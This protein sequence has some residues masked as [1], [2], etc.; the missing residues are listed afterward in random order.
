MTQNGQQFEQAPSGST[1]AARPPVTVVEGRRAAIASRERKR[2]DGIASDVRYWPKADIGY[3]AAHVRFRRESRHDLLRMS[4]FAVA[5]GGKAD[6]AF[7][8]AYVG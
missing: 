5:I 8:T 4:A 1:T 3:C 2:S 7:C 6:M